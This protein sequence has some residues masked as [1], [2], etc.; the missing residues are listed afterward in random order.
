MMVKLYGLGRSA[1]AP[2]VLEIEWG[3]AAHLG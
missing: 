2:E 1:P 3:F